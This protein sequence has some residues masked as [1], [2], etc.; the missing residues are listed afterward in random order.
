[1]PGFAPGGVK[2]K[3]MKQTLFLA[4][5]VVLVCWNTV[6]GEPRKT[7]AA[8]ASAEQKIAAEETV[9]LSNGE[10]PPYYGAN[11]PHYGFD[12]H[13]VSEA[14]ALVGLKVVYKFYPW[15]RAL[16]MSQTGEC[17]GGVGW[18]DSEEYRKDHY[19]S[20]TTSSYSF[21][22]FHR[23][24]YPFEWKTYGNLKGLRVG[25]TIAYDYP[26]ELK[27][28]ET[29]GEIKVERVPRDEQNFRKL[30]AKRIDIFPNDITAGMSQMKQ[31][32]TPEE[33]AEIVWH[34]TA[35]KAGTLHL[36]L[37]KKKER[38]ARLIK[39]FDEGLKRLK[40]NGTYDAVLQAAQRGEYN[41]R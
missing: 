7:G 18:G 15:G 16:Y 24:D 27:I 19:I 34:H 3:K 14:F 31:I 21:V 9:Y 11:L 28:M 17:D 35:L 26:E 25:L 13:I 33:T 12:S 8:E 41:H 4:G 32:F 20:E 37:S 36:V 10:W 23:K 29:E 30:L 38:N 22:F 1:M 5:I 6:S 40:E 2:R 39:L